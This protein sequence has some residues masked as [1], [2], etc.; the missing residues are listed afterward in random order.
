MIGLMAL[1]PFSWFWCCTVN[2]H[3][4]MARGARDAFQ[5][6]MEHNS[7]CAEKNEEQMGLDENGDKW[8][9]SEG[10]WNAVHNLTLNSILS[11]SG[12]GAYIKACTVPLLRAIFTA[13]HTHHAFS[14][15]AQRLKAG[16]LNPIFS[17]YQ[18]TDQSLDIH[19]LTEEEL[20]YTGVDSLLQYHRD[21]EEEEEYFIGQ[22]D[23]EEEIPFF[24]NV[25]VVEGNKWDGH[26]SGSGSQGEDDDSEDD[27]KDHFE[28]K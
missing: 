25:H 12:S 5:G 27:P 1:M 8:E 18:R 28:E 26:T 7:V 2:G 6:Y 22:D 19:A 24:L 23:D 16:V 13:V 3:F 9:N 15:I 17:R 11:Q 14:H 20:W 4:T 10:S 21:I